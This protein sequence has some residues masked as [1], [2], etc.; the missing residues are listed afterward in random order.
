MIAELTGIVSRTSGSFL[1]LNVGGVGYKV[2]V[3]LT[4]L[5]RLPE[6]SEP[7]TLMIHTQVREDDISLYGF[8]EQTELSVFELLLSVSGVG[9]KVA[10]G[11]LSASTADDLAQAISSEDVR[12]LTRVPGVGAKTAQRM[13][14]ELKDKI[15]QFGF[16]RRVDQIK[17]GDSVKKRDSNLD[18]HEDA[19]SA[20]TNLGYA[21]PESQRAVDLALKEM[22]EK[23]SEPKFADL[24]R[25]SLN[26]LTKK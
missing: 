5:E 23:T 19:V 9:P 18:L 14:L 15:A 16:E 1:V 12:S 3:P 4:V 21:K 25:A 7:L 10:L 26:K 22:L 20:L 11:L 17:S 24:L 8:L 6:N 13:V 2:S